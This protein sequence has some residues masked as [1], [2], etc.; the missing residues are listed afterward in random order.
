MDGDFENAMASLPQSRNKLEDRRGKDNKMSR[1]VWK[2][3][4]A[5]AGKIRMAEIEGGRGKGGSRKEMRRKRGK[6]ETKKGEDDGSKES[7]RRMENME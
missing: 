1:G 3:V 7:S 6:E 2:T 5:N 4:E